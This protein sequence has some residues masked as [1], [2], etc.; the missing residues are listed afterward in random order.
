MQDLHLA[1]LLGLLGRLMAGLRPQVVLQVSVAQGGKRAGQ[2]EGDYV[3]DRHHDGIFACN[4]SEDAKPGGG[5]GQAEEEHVNDA[6]LEEPV[7]TRVDG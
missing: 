3:E 6:R 4:V 5:D 1:Q 2:E 7:G